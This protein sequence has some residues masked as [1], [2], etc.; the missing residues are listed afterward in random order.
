MS[1]WIRVI[2]DARM[3]P[4]DIPDYL[5]EQL[6]RDFEEA[7]ACASLSP[8]ACVV[9]CRRCVQFMI[10]DF[11]G[12]QKRNLASEIDELDESGRIGSETSEMLGCLRKMGN[13]GAHPPSGCPPED[14][15]STV[16]DISDANDAL[17]ITR[18]LID[19][20]YVRKH[21]RDAALNRLRARTAKN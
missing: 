3:E 21:D 16:V 11:W 10:R 9:L 8:R 15:F 14:P 19:D 1:G 20:W 4:V 13:K 5:P 7:S 18:A 17:T 6:K 2:P 12:I